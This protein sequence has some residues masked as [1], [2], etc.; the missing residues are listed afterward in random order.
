[1]KKFVVVL[2]FFSSFLY[3]DPS[4]YFKCGGIDLWA[5]GNEYDMITSPEYKS[6]DEFNEKKLPVFHVDYNYKDRLVFNNDTLDFMTSFKQD[7]I[8]DIIKIN[9]KTGGFFV[10]SKDYKRPFDVNTIIFVDKEYVKTPV[11]INSDEWAK[12]VDIDADDYSYNIKAIAYSNDF[13][14][15]HGALI[16]P[17]EPIKCTK[18]TTMISLYPQWDGESLDSLKLTVYVE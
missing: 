1:M 16:I 4:L 13:L 12:L 5:A 3:A 14:N 10:K 2:V 9:I 17:F 18:D 15:I 11:Y 7:T 8:I 6:Q